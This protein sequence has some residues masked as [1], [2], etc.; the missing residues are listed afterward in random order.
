M[1]IDKIKYILKIKKNVARAGN[2]EKLGSSYNFNKAFSVP[3]FS[4]ANVLNYNFKFNLLLFVNIQSFDF[5]QTN[6]D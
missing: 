2:I 3:N 4:M 1:Q 5:N 6:F